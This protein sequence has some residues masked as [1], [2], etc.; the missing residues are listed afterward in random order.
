MDLKERVKK[1]LLQPAQEW[2][3]I[4][5]EPSTVAD[6]YKSYIAPLAAIGPAA[7]VFGLAVVGV[8]SYRM[9]FFTAVKHA[10]V[11][12]ILMLVGVYVVALIIDTLAPTFAG[13]K[14]I[15]QALKVAAYSN[16]AAWVCGIFNLF[17]ALGVL[18]IFGLYGLYLLY[19]GLPILM[20]VRQDTAVLNTIIVAVAA[21]LVLAVIGAVSG[22]VV[23]LRRL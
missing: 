3:V 1:I 19:L 6:L 21:F 11:T 17:P 15:S 8:G 5:K 20:R 4:A 7:S 14:N 2:R 18:Q 22:A 13:V 16:T 12:Y 10:L 9:S 23:P